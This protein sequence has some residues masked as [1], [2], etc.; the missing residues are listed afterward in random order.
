MTDVDNWGNTK[1]ENVSK[2]LTLNYQ[3]YRFVPAS[4]NQYA[5]KFKNFTHS[6]FLLYHTEPTD[7]VSYMTY[8]TVMSAISALHQFHNADTPMRKK[9]LSSYLSALNKNQNWYRAKNYT[10]Y[11]LTP[12][13]EVLDEVLPLEKLSE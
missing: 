10:V 9:L 5:V 6:Y 8:V 3:S 11:R 4:F 2:A 1:T 13:G 12:Q 7:A